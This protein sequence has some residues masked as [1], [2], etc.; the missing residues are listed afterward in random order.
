M[1]TGKK[2]TIGIILKVG[3]YK[4]EKVNKIKYLGVTIAN[5]GKKETEIKEKIIAVNRTYNANK[6][7]LRS[8]YLSKKTKIRMYETLIR[9]VMMYAAETMT[10][11]DEEE[12]RILERKILRTILGP[13]RVAHDE[14][15]MRMNHELKQEIGEDIAQRIKKQRIKWLGHVWR[16]VEEAHIRT[17]MTWRPSSLRRRGR[18]RSR[19]MEEVT[20]DLEEKGVRNWQRKAMDRRL[21]RT[22][23]LML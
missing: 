22:I 4:F 8:K 13:V 5:D 3:N 2:I 23:S 16:A 21:W 14:Y 20:R 10:Q 17:L 12:L 9:P 11:R 1:E 18:P 6:K 19:W 15:R 7:M